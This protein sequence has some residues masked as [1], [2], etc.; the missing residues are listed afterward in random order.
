MNIN[1]QRCDYRSGCHKKIIISAD[2]QYLAK[3]QNHFNMKCVNIVQD[4]CRDCL[5]FQAHQCAAWKVLNGQDQGLK[6]VRCPK[7]IS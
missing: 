7:K 1:C 3:E 6:L 2:R 5:R 4:V